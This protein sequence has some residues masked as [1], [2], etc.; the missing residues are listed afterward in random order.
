M[1]RL[2]ALLLLLV[3]GPARAESGFPAIPIGTPLDANG[4]PKGWTLIDDIQVPEDFLSTEKGTYMT[5]LWPDGIVPYE[6]DPELSFANRARA[7]DAMD[8]IEAVSAVVFRPADFD[9]AYI[10]IRS[11][12]QDPEPGNNAPVGYFLGV[13]TVN[14]ASWTERWII[15]HELMHVL[16][17]WH[18]QS[19]TDR[20]DSVEIITQNIQGG[21]EHNFDIQ[22]L[23]ENYGPY[24]FG[25]VMHYSACAFSICGSTNCSP[26]LATCRTIRVL[27]PNDTQWQSGI[28]QRSQFSEMDALTLS[29]LYPQS[30]WRF[31]DDDD[32]TLIPGGTFLDPW[33]TVADGESLTPSGGTLF[34]QPGNYSETL[35]L[36]RNLR[37][38]APLGGVTIGN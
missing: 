34:I 6:F 25:S 4:I 29:F 21:K 20:D 17:F 33:A 24:D 12:L 13:H 7:R 37:I 8:E 16:G 23:S 3:A 26:T 5:L 35:T 11:S 38:E 15:V 36:D 19:R 9:V 1:W 14:I 27:P 22:L 10:S 31:V 30:N 2:L 18:E 28:G 32:G